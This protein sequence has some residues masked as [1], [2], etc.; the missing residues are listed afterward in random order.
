[1][2]ENL[3]LNNFWQERSSPEYL[4][5]ATKERKNPISH[6]RE[7]HFPIFLTKMRRFIGTLVVIAFVMVT[8]TV[9]VMVILLR[10]WLHHFLFLAEGLR[11]F[12][13]FLANLFG[14][15]LNLLVIV[16]I[17]KVFE[18]ISAKLTRWGE[19]IKLIILIMNWAT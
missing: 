9:H 4:F 5:Y 14:S 15:F 2:K 17:D 13:S 16:I 7:P 12:S 1:M 6:C 19:I 10:M 3:C 11:P 8:I 18:K